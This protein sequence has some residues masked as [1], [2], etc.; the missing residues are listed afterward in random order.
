MNPGPT[1]IYGDVSTLMPFDDGAGKEAHFTFVVNDVAELIAN[2]GPEKVMNELFVRYPAVY[3]AI[4][5]HFYTDFFKNKSVE[6][7]PAE[8]YL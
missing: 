1:L 4:C 3:A 7:P 6:R 5:A 8:V 2:Y